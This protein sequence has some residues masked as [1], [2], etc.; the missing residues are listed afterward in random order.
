V[1]YIMVK[2]LP[3]YPVL[4]PDHV[5]HTD[6]AALHGGP[7]MVRSA[8]TVSTTVVGGKPVFTAG[9]RSVGLNI[10]PDELDSFFLNQMLNWS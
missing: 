1:K 10:G 6:M 9:G 7:A 3:D 5:K 4:F 8:G 2:G